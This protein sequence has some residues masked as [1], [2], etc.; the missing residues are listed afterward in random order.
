MTA[1]TEVFDREAGECIGVDIALAKL[2]DD[3]HPEVDGLVLRV[4]VCPAV[5]GIGSRIVSPAIFAFERM[6][7][8]TDVLEHIK[9]D[10]EN[11]AAFGR[12]EGEIASLAQETN[13][14]QIGAERRFLGTV[15]GPA[16]VKTLINAGACF[17]GHQKRAVVVDPGAGLMCQTDTLDTAVIGMEEPAARVSVGLRHKARHCPGK[18]GIRK[19]VAMGE[20]HNRR[21]THADIDIRNEIHIVKSFLFDI[22]S[23]YPKNAL[24]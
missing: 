19:C 3:I 24:L 23:L 17:R 20:A 9:V 5:K 14:E 1:L 13:L 12:N 8:Q 6:E 16:A 7:R 10:L 15:A 22:V 18:L 11:T 4:T 21:R 2:H